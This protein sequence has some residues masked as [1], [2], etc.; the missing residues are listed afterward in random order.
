MKVLARYGEKG[1][2][3]IVAFSRG[4][5]RIFLT[6][7]HLEVCLGRDREEIGW[8]EDAVERPDPEPDA[9]LLRRGVE[10]VLRR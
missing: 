9:D 6:A 1:D 3:A 8:P 7:V 4:R 2:P 5:G 10:W